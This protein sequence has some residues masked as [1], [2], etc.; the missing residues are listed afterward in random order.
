MNVKLL[1]MTKVFTQ[2]LRFLKIKK[3]N[4]DDY[5]QLLQHNVYTKIRF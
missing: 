5:I 3:E 2:I 1:A 4:R